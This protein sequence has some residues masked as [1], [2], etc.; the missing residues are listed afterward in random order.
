MT[1][2]RMPGVWCY[3]DCR[4]CKA[5]G[6]RRFESL[7]DLQLALSGRTLLCVKCGG[8][9]LNVHVP[10]PFPRDVVDAMKREADL[11]TTIIGLDGDVS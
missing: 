7:S 6:E 8:R 9:M 10:G 4:S 2:L 3:F 1:A 11:G 5:H